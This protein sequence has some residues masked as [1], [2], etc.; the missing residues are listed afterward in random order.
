MTFAGIKQKLAKLNWQ[1]TG[2]WLLV[3][4]GVVAPIICFGVATIGGGAVLEN[5]GWQDG[6]IATYASLL[7][8]S[9][10]VVIFSPFL[11]YCV[12]SLICLL[13]S[14]EEGKERFVVRF[15]IYSGFPLAAQYCWIIYC[16]N[17]TLPEYIFRFVPGIGLLAG[18][19]VLGI[20]IV[21]VTKLAFSWSVKKYGWNV[22]LAVLAILLFLYVFFSIIIGKE[23][24]LVVPFAVPF[25]YAL[26]L[27]PFWS[28]C[29]YTGYTL[30]LLY[31]RRKIRFQFGLKRAFAVVTW[32]AGYF[33][34]WRI[35]VDLMLVEY[36]KLPKEAP[37]NCFVATAAARGH[38]GFVKGCEVK[39]RSGECIR[40]SQQMQI[41][42]GAELLL[43]AIF[44][45]A[46]RLL[47]RFY[48]HF[49]PKLASHISTP[50]RADAAY[51]ALK[52][53]EWLALVVF[54]MLLNHNSR[55]ASIS[56]LYK[57]PRE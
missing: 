1:K 34:A 45:R 39:T 23:E 2:A 4:A 10:T 38:S 50:W 19:T 42:K 28:L 21:V 13:W 6:E 51:L 7:M 25:I 35:S 27:G 31:A 36:A 29:I 40:V 33:A 24:F 44:P 15:G 48:N 26:V 57:K 43:R 17:F 41:L 5:S 55:T 22:P 52:P 12:Y 30:A 32:I 18:V 53:A 9:P 49:G 20:V 47:R 16:R 56:R 54:K 8:S 37:Q 46:H 3:C 14:W 11:F